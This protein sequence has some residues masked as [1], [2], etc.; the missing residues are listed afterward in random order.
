[1]RTAKACQKNARAFGC[2]ESEL[3][4]SKKMVRFLAIQEP[5]NVVLVI[6]WLTVIY[7]EY[8]FYAINGKI[9]CKHF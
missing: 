3:K 9:T 4:L 6:M 1:M 8:V 7:G 2:K 5:F